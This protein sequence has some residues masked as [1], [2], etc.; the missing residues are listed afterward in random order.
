MDYSGVSAFGVLPPPLCVW[1]PQILYLVA[2]SDFFP[3]QRLHWPSSEAP[4][5]TEAFSPPLRIQ[6][7]YFA[8]DGESKNNQFSIFGNLS[9]FTYT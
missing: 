7:S 6:V 4:C 1:V 8:M 2:T 5:V 9:Q 3:P